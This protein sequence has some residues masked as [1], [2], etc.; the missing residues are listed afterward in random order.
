MRTRIV[1]DG[2]KY[3]LITHSGK[4]LFAAGSRA[5]VVAEATR[6]RAEARAGRGPLVALSAE[7][8]GQGDD[9]PSNPSQIAHL[10]ATIDLAS[11]PGTV[12]PIMQDEVDRLSAIPLVDSDGNEIPRIFR[13]SFILRPGTFNG[14]PF[15][16]EDVRAYHANHAAKVR[17]GHKLPPIQ[18]E[19]ELGVSHKNGLVVSTAINDKPADGPHLHAILEYR[20]SRA[21]EA[22]EAGLWEHLS[23]SFHTGLKEILEVSVVEDPAVGHGG[24]EKAR[25][26]GHRRNESTPTPNP[27]K[28]SKNEG[29]QTV[30]K[31]LLSR[32]LS[33]IFGGADSASTAKLSTKETN[34]VN[35]I[36]AHKAD[37]SDPAT[38]ALALKVAKA[39][40]VDLSAVE[41]VLEAAVEAEDDDANG[42]AS[43]AATP[44]TSTANLSNDLGEKI[45]GV[46]AGL[47]AKIDELQT[48][49]LS[50]DEKAADLAD[51]Q[52]ITDLVKSGHVTPANKESSL[53]VLKSL[54]GDDGARAQFLA[55][56]SSKRVLNLGRETV[57]EGV[58]AKANTPTSNASEFMALAAESMGLT[59]D[60]KGKVVKA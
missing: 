39:S 20:G 7:G 47:S 6:L 31:G 1:K 14:H 18:V 56:L 35:D 3:K 29:D 36:K 50:K 21:V 2:G 49:A 32:L 58:E 46:I 13:E 17:L 24:G 34:L 52:A 19:H 10:S 26:L 51:D 55:V 25:M 33:G 57:D 27:Q 4:E 15:P 54:R 28:L 44:T 60:E 37:L 11:A 5:E 9:D 38:A 43:T 53:A 41:A 59:L 23:G 8:E 40:G 45:M 42:S 48:A 12:T 30:K 22:V 16:A